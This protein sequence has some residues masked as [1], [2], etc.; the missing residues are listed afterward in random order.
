MPHNVINYDFTGS[1]I[2]IMHC[3]SRTQLLMVPYHRNIN[4]CLI[5]IGIAQTPE[6][7]F[8]Q[9]VQNF[10]K[11][12]FPYAGDKYSC[13]T[14][15]LKCLSRLACSVSKQSNSLRRI[16]FRNSIATETNDLNFSLARDQKP[17]Q[18]CVQPRQAHTFFRHG[19]T[20][21]SIFKSGGISKHLMPGPTR[22]TIYSQC[23][24]IVFGNKRTPLFWDFY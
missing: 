7:I 11:G 10:T 6:V 19:R 12:I 13:Y 9:R 15:Q 5:H 14:S 1:M 21:C 20:I 24:N 23:S 3:N 2:P 16:K 8:I 22:N 4:F 18:I 17:R